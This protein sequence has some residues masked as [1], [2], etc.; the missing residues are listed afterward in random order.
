[1]GSSSR[2][3]N[4]KAKRQHYVPRFYLQGFS[5]QGKQHHLYCFDKLKLRTSKQNI[6]NMGCENYFYDTSEDVVQQTEKNLSYL[7]SLWKPTCAKLVSTR[8][9]SRLTFDERKLMAYFVATQLVRTRKWRQVLKGLPLGFAEGIRQMAEELP[10]EK[11]FRE[12]REGIEVERLMLK[13]LAT[14][15]EAIKDLHITSLEDIPEY[16]YIIC[17]KR[18]WILFVNHTAMPFWCSDHPITR[19]NPINPS[20]YGSLGILCKGVEIHCPLSPDI[21]LCICDS[22]MYHS[23][24]SKFEINDVQDIELQNS[25]QVCW[26]ARYIFSN[27]NDFSLA[28]RM[29]KYDPSLA[30][31]DRER[32]SVL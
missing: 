22:T 14:D 16:V 13:K 5:V 25:F 9:V 8:D 32:M 27:Q 2:G 23:R 7:E 4:P 28:E 31:I 18:K 20:P 17:N 10:Q 6:K 12:L 15:E 3:V 26:S 11:R 24:P 30:H 19:N 1:M 29:I 21:S